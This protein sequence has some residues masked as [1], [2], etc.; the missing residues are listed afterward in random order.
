MIPYMDNM[1]VEKRQWLERRH[2]VMVLR[3]AKPYLEQRR[4]KPPLTSGSGREA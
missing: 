2:F 1:A 4:C 3:S